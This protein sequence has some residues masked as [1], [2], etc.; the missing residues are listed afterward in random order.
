MSQYTQNEE[1]TLWVNKVGPYHNPQETYPYFSLPYCVPEKMMVSGKAIKHKWDGIG[2]LLEGNDLFDSGLHVKF[3]E[4]YSGVY[5]KSK[6]QQ[7]DV[8]DFVYAVENH[9][10]FQLYF[11]VDL[12]VVSLNFR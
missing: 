3:R 10:W 2:S 9:Y 8:D 12:V 5:C 1:V 11:G 7:D 6:L 4:D